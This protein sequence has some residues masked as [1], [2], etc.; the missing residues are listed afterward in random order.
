MIDHIFASIILSGDFQGTSFRNIRYMCYMILLLGQVAEFNNW[1]DNIPEMNTGKS[2]QARNA[3]DDDEE[4]GKMT[5]DEPG[6]CS[7]GQYSDYDILS[8]YCS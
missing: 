1:Q 6:V 2:S 8:L 3:F 5:H 7:F 4:E